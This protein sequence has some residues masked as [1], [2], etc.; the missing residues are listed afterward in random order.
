MEGS[1]NGAVGEARGAFVED[2]LKEDAHAVGRV[3]CSCGSRAVGATEKR[4]G[5]M[6]QIEEQEENVEA[7]EDGHYAHAHTYR[8]MHTHKHT[9]THSVEVNAC[10]MCI[11][12]KNHILIPCGHVCVCEQCASCIMASSRSVPICNNCCK[13][14]QSIL[15]R[16]SHDVTCQLAH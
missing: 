4:F 6:F 12:V 8:H 14:P 2:E 11:G 15:L 10:A 16:G 7:G 9:Q 1:G 5:K 13:H 3:G